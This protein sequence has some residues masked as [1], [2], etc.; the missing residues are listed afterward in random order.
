[1]EKTFKIQFPVPLDSSERTII[2]NASVR[3]H[4]SLPHYK[5]SDI[6]LAG[7]AGKQPPLLADIDIK[8]VDREGVMAWVHLDSGKTS[9]L[10]LAAGHAIENKLKSAVHVA[11]NEAGLDNTDGD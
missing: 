5:V 3:L 9:I 7:S 4:H 6:N 2:L 10:S 1:V 8:C 11:E